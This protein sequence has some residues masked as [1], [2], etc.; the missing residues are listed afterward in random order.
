[1]L[2]TLRKIRND[3]EYR[4]IN[5]A[6]N[7][8]LCLGSLGL[9]QVLKG[10][11][12]AAFPELLPLFFA[13][14]CAGSTLQGGFSDKYKRSIVLNISYIIIIV[15]LSSL[16]MIHSYE[17]WLFTILR[18][19]CIIL[20]GLGGNADVVGRA[21]VIDMHYHLDRRKVM[22][23][24]VF[25]E[26]FSWI[27][28]GA[29]IRFLNLDP[30][31]ILGL[32]IPF[33]ALLLGISL[34]FNTDKTEGREQIGSVFHEIKILIRN[35]K[36]KLSWITT[37]V[38]L[39]ELGYFF[40][41]YNQEN[42]IR[43]S[44]ILADSYIAWFL[45]MSLGSLILSKFKKFSD[46]SLSIFGLGVSFVSIVIFIFGGMKSINDPQMFYYDSFVYALAGLG[47]GFYL[48]CFYSI[49][50]RGHS[51]HFQGMLT[52]W[53]DSLRVLG[54]ATSNAILAGIGLMAFP[55]FVPIYVSGSLFIA[56]IFAIC[57]SKQKLNKN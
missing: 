1:M 8:A 41:F 24:T 28:V 12:V 29:I 32:C 40:F 6:I 42:H 47:S 14:Q 55:K 23:W 38:I 37:I 46:L 25:S 26:A 53:I 15:M 3:P 54:D 17:G 7:T 45:G 35:N 5:H 31:N 19:S 43:N 50:S 21:E 36:A 52:G 18:G 13:V 4:K 16:M 33:T 9:A 20:I 27:L 22:S 51:I 34:L 57:L 10:T 56:T 11:I 48:P 30:F 39:G 2:T 44:R 49:I